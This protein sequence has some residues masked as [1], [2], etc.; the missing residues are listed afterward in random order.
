MNDETPENL[1]KVTVT[2]PLYRRKHHFSVGMEKHRRRMSSSRSPI[3]VS[4][5]LT[6]NVVTTEPD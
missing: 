2:V 3:G 1:Q 5:E 6:M 4:Y